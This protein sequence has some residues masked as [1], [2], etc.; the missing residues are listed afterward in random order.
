MTASPNPLNYS[1]GKGD[2][3][4][5]P[6]GGVQR[7]MGNAP[8]FIITP[9]AEFLDHFSSRSGVGIKDRSIPT[10]LSATLQLLIDEITIENL[11]IALFGDDPVA[12]SDGDQAFRM[13]TNAV[14]EGR[15]LFVG[16]NEVGPRYRVDCDKV[17]FKPQEDVPFI[18]EEIA[19]LTLSG[20][21]LEVT[22]GQGFGEVVHIA[23]EPST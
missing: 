19:V 18:S 20:E 1:L 15:V 17:Q 9:S 12:N 16:A 4:F 23:D 11:A 21:L 7:H 22:S 5:T 3:Y 2:V 10:R 13:M 8:G 14:R 6:V